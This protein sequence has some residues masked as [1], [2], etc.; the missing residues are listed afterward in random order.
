MAMIGAAALAAGSLLVPMAVA[1]DKPEPEHYSAVWAVVGGGAGGSTTSIDIRI[2]RYN[3]SEDIMRYAELLKNS[4]QDSL[5]RKLEDEDVGQLSPVGS[6]GTPIAIARKLRHGDKTIIR[7][8]TA[9][10]MSFAELRNSGRSVDYPFT[11]LE[12]KLDKTGK[13]AG[14]VIR[15]AKI[16]FDKKKNQYEIESLGHGTAYNKLLNVRTM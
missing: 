5:R 12:F 10:Y 8:L 14:T 1:Q 13:G 16:R 15:A 6:V 3:T 4:G 2:N 11:M 7:V 9:R